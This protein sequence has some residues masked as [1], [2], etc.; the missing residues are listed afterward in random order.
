MKSNKYI[1]GIAAGTLAFTALIANPATVSAQEEEGDTVAAKAVHTLFR[2]QDPDRILGG[3]V[4][5]DYTELQ[6]KNFGSVN[7]ISL[8]NTGNFWGYGGGLVLIDG[9]PANNSVLYDDIES[10]TYIKGAQAVALYGSRGV[11]G[12]ILVKTKRG[13]NEPI[14]ITARGNFGMGFDKAYPELL[15]SAEYMMFYNKALENDGLS[16]KYSDADI[17]YSASG[18]NPYLY[19]DVDFYSSDYIKN[20]FCGGDV[21]MI[22]EGGND[23][24][25]FYTDIMAERSGDQFKFGEAKNNYASTLAIRGN[26]DIHLTDRI[27]AEVDA[28]VNM[29]DVRSYV[30]TSYWSAAASQRP[31]RIAP[32]I[33][34]SMISSTAL[35]ALD[36]MKE[37]T[38]II[39][40]KYFLSGT[41]EDATNVFA[42]IYSGGK[43]K[44][45]NR[46]F[47][48]NTQL[49]FDLRDLLE[50]LSFHTQFGMEYATTY[51]TSF[52]NQYAVY[53]PTWFD[54]GNGEVITNLKKENENKKTG[55]QNVGGS[56][57]RRMFAF[58]AH[59]DYDHSFGDHTVG[60]MILVNGYQKAVDGEYHKTS[61]ADLS[62][63]ANYNF[64]K[65]Y[66]A[67]V[68]FA[69]P[70]SA[71][72]A[73]GHRNGFSKSMSLGW[74]I[75]NEP[76]FDKSSV[77]NS[78]TFSFS[79][80]DLCEDIDISDYYMYAGTW[81]FEEGWYSWR[82]GNGTQPTYSVRGENPELDFIH[83]KELST[84]VKVS[85]LQNSL[86]FD[87]S[88]FTS[89]Q[90]GLIITPSLVPSY[91]TSYYP[92]ASFISYINNNENTFKGIDFGINYT[93]Q[94]GEVTVGLGVF[95]STMVA[96][97][98]KRDESNIP[99]L[100]GYNLDADGNKIYIDKDGNAT[101]SEFDANGMQNGPSMSTD[102]R[103]REGKYLDGVWGYESLGYF[104]T[105]EEID[106]YATYALGSDKP[107]RPGDIKYKDQNNDGVIDSKDQVELGR[108][109]WYG[110]PFSM[111]FN[112]SASYRNFTLFV[113]GHGNFGTTSVKNSEYYWV[114][115]EDKYTAAVRDTWTEENPNAK[116]P[117]LTTGNGNN[118]F[119]TSDFWTFKNNVF[120][121]DKIQL[122]YDFPSSMFEN[123]RIIKGCSVYVY[124]S[125]LLTISKERELLERS[126][127]S[128]PQ[129]RFYN[130]GVKVNF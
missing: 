128:A 108:A 21:S 130:F 88:M 37:N 129:Y 34:L 52:N 38:N 5:V 58:N 51:T 105:Q 125:N 104:K 81:S 72:L 89:K 43:S 65:R 27:S 101:K 23:K 68:T 44:A 11:N 13:K 107:L 93:K 2:D 106:N 45:T 113:A 109:G 66:Y 116:Y 127:G 100:E 96:K 14:S 17:Y 30:G 63:N 59:L 56:S 62:F 15:G 82:E 90:A 33:P 60:G 49:H 123:N 115:G 22:I 64:A 36:L 91:F 6:K 35:D 19:P 69:I 20:H 79:A 25:T 61:N 28:N 50:G 57:T 124:G 26:V 48:F 111:G 85:M 110:A 53:I 1:S 40:G 46:Q 99:D 39:D 80:S 112:V 122:S 32:L 102:Y 95:G 8:A 120:Y 97:A 84:N 126:Y 76:F 9:L 18:E 94:F 41:Q 42:N 87:F 86:V 54:L 3:V 4:T 10:I 67:D 121:L 103:K 98:G 119:Q 92:G 117:R 77:I 78:L 73:E 55:T 47:Q 31:N 7:A 70:H 12:V 16:A 74:N 118:N 75:A 114:N 24:A 83:R 71:K 29:H